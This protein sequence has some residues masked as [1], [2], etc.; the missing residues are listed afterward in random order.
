MIDVMLHM[1]LLRIFM[2]RQRHRFLMAVRRL[3]NEDQL[4]VVPVGLEG[5]LLIRIAQELD[6]L[7]SIHI[8]PT[9]H[10]VGLVSA[11]IDLVHLSR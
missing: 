10:R 11:V 3:L 7:L 8:D 5:L 2:L 9:V 6:R 1:S 4:R